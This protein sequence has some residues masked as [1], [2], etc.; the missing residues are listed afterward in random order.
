MRWKYVKCLAKAFFDDL[1]FALAIPPIL[2][3]KIEITIIHPETLYNKSYQ[4]V[5]Y[6]PN[7][8]FSSEGIIGS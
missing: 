1:A 5:Q 3:V 4:E 2:A 7:S 6:I 8:T